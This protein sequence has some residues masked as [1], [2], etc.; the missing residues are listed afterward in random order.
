MTTVG[1]DGTFEHWGSDPVGTLLYTSDHRMSAALATRDLTKTVVT[2]DSSSAGLDDP[3]Q[4][5][6]TYFGTWR[7]DEPNGAVIHAVQHASWEGLLE[8][9]QVRYYR[10]DGDRLILRTPPVKVDGGYQHAEVVF[11]RA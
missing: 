1:P 7:V 3:L 10:F 9:E 8:A 5:F 11:Q 4:G 2:W 6:V